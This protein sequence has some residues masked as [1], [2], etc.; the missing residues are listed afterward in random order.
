MDETKPIGAGR[1]SLEFLLRSL[2]EDRGQAA[3]NYEALRQKLI[4]FF[5]WK[6]SPAPEDLADLT[7]DRMA[8]KIETG[9]SPQHPEKYAYSVARFL[10]LEHGREQAKEKAALYELELLRRQRAGDPAEEQSL[11]FLE[12]CLAALGKEHSG[13][14]LRYYQGDQRER[15]ENRKGMGDKQGVSLNALRNKALRLRKRL[16]NCLASKLGR[17]KT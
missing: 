2:G 16:E 5:S 12:Q 10:L 8:H 15:I 6:G 9:E 13:F 7:L 14:I 4:R 11:R 17:V 3:E 1:G